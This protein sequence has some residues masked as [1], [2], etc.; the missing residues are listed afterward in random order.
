MKKLVLVF[1]LFCSFVNAQSLVE[2]RGYLQKGE[3]SEEVSKTLQTCA[4]PISYDTTKKPIYM[5]FYAVGNFFMAKHASNPLNKYSYFNKGK[6]LLEDAIKKEPNNIEIRL[7]RLISQEK[8]PSFLGYNKNIEADRN[9]II[10][11]YKNSDDENL[12]KFI[13]N[14]LKI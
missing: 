2:L 9:F 11:N 14:Y 10:K 5:A 8:T 4:L 13:K 12:V 6:K 3:N 7:M 1:L